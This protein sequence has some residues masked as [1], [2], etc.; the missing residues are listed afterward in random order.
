MVFKPKP[1]HGQDI[2]DKLIE[3]FNRYREHKISADE[4]KKTV[5]KLAVGVDQ[6]EV[7]DFIRNTL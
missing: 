6:A 5:R 4:Y 7:E 3:T 2:I 1:T